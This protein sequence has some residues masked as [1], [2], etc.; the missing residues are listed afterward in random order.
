MRNTCGTIFPVFSLLLF[1]SGRAFAAASSSGL[2]IYSLDQTLMFDPFHL[3]ED[4]TPISIRRVLAE[5]SYATAL[6][7]AFKLNEQPLIQEV[8]ENVP[9][10]TSKNII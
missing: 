9:I 6:M 4:I 1:F 7:M 3:D 10:D 8:I 2:L 5:P